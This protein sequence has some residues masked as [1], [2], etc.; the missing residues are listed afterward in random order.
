V[1]VS[2]LDI[3]ELYTRG[4]VELDGV[5]DIFAPLPHEFDLHA[6]LLQDLAYGRVV[7]KLVTFYVPARRGPHPELAM[8]M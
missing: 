4:A 1:L 7:G 2:G 6:R 3:L 8:E 5:L